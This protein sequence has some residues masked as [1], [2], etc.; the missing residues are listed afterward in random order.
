MESQAGAG[1]FALIAVREEDGWEVGQLPA[2]LMS[3]LDGILAAL[4]QQ[5]GVGGAIALVDVADEFFVA[6][7]VV[8]GQRRFLLSDATAAA[9]WDLARDVLTELGMDVPEGDELDEIQPAGDLAIFADYG[10][11]E[12]ALETLL[13]DVDAYADEILLAIAQR[14]G[15]ADELARIIDG[16]TGG[17]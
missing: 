7:R 5:L 2:R 17:G 15:F 16:G 1:G 8:G 6:V 12:V 11:D 9:E 14:L 13:S 3:D 4:R 10:L